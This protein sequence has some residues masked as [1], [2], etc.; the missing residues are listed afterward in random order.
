MFV[1]IAK[2][3]LRADDRH[4]SMSRKLSRKVSCANAI[5]RN[6]SVQRNLRTRTSPPY[7]ITRRSKLVHGTKSMTCENS[8]RPKFTAALPIDK[9]WENYRGFVKL[10]SN[11]HQI[12]SAKGAKAAA[13]GS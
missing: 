1:G 12:K 10:R 4:A 13:T 11:R 3:Q 5:A 8:V 7:F 9:N 2:A 6:C